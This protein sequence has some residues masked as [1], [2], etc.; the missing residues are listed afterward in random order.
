[1]CSKEPSRIKTAQVRAPSSVSR[2]AVCVRLTKTG[3][4]LIER[5]VRQLLDHE[6]SL[7]DSF[8]TAERMTLLGLLAKLERTLVTP[9][10]DDPR[11]PDE[12]RE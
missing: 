4:S 1:M 12:P 2:R 9:A 10:T 8:T 11:E 7:I 6:A 3:H 5:T